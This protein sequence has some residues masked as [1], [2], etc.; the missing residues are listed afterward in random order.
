[1][2]A[3]S[4]SRSSSAVAIIPARIG[5]TRLPR[6]PLADLAGAPLVWRVYAQVS[7]C[8]ALDSVYVATDDDAIEAAV[9][10]RGGQV[11]R[12]DIQCASGTERVALAARQ[13]DA[14]WILNVQGDE[15]F[16]EPALLTDLVDRLRRGAA[17][18]TACAPLDERDRANPSVVKVVRNAE[19][20]ALY[21]SRAPI[22]GEQHV[23]VYGFRADVLQAAAALPRSPAARAEDLEQLTW[24]HHGWRV[25]VCDAPRAQLSIDTPTE[26]AQA[27]ARFTAEV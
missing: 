11:I 6:K 27:A 21:F 20:Q 15:P 7:A 3:P 23:G 18:V 24:L 19:G 12:V 1:M 16:I 22:P 13:L 10:S 17:I 5:S 8:E 2:R 9:R 26:L 25:A 14:S 4:S